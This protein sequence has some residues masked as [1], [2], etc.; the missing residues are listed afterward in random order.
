[1]VNIRFFSL[2]TVMALTLS[3]CTA[4]RAADKSDAAAAMASFTD[5]EATY[6][7]LEGVLARLYHDCMEAE[8]FDVHPVDYGDLPWPG[9]PW[10]GNLDT[11]TAHSAPTRT[12]AEESGYS[13]SPAEMEEQ[14]AYQ[15]QI[16]ESE[17]FH[18]AKSDQDA[19][20]IAFRGSATWGD[21]DPGS[22][23]GEYTTEDGTTILY[24][25]SGCQPEVLNEVFEGD[26]VTYFELK[27]TIRTQLAG[28][29]YSG[30]NN[31]PAVL[32]AQDSW[33]QCMRDEGTDVDHPLDAMQLALDLWVGVE[34]TSGAEFQTIKDEEIALAL[35]HVDCDEAVGFRATYE[36]T[37]HRMIEE[38]LLA[39]ETELFAWA[40]LM[41]SGL[42]N[43]QAL[44]AE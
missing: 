25:E 2:A 35:V 26:I 15:N 18:T 5:A 22:T 36:D 23:I 9:L 42:A 4:D 13:A 8:G 33:A 27:D 31:D 3:A 16:A 12:E 40:Q 43:A 29:T 44:L 32:E 20:W 11:M 39:H 6:Q 17:F 14:L 21:D 41:D 30:V 10:Q 37:F 28:V 24:P 1:M 38:H 34:A 7:E 19:Y